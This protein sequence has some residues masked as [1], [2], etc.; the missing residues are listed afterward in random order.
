VSVG[1]REPRK[2]AAFESPARLVSPVGFDPTMKRPASTV[3]GV[4]LVYL[5]VLA[6]I[7][8]LAALWLDHSLLADADLNLE[9]ITLTTEDR[10]LV[11]IVVTVGM[12]IFLIADAILGSL[13]LRGRNTPR[14]I[15][16]IFSTLSICS[17]FTA[18]WLQEEDVHLETTLLTVAFDI[19][20][21]L[22][23]SSRNSAAYARRFERR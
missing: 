19:L 7:L 8:W 11:L 14:V 9:G 16:M 21:L 22:A 6:G 23:L 1:G 17:A 4:V 5:R 20:I 15:V 3:A 2:R 18:W 12:G 13:I 10:S